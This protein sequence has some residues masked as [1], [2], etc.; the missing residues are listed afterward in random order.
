[1]SVKVRKQAVLT[2]CQV[3]V[4][5]GKP[6]FLKGPSA[7]VTEEILDSVLRVTL[8]DASP[9]IRQAL[10]RFFDSRFDVYFCRSHHI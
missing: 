7:E 1:P 6:Q 4:Q 8:S 9:N 2:S 10:V 5:P 3:L